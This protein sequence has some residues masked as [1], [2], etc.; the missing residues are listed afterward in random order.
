M[1]V[2]SHMVLESFVTTAGASVGVGEELAPK[3]AMEIVTEGPETV[4]GME[5]GAEEME[6]GAVAVDDAA[7]L[8]EAGVEVERGTAG[9]DEGRLSMVSMKGWTMLVRFGKSG[10]G[11]ILVV[12]STTFFYAAVLLQCF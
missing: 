5:E 4:G 12:K 7:A 8:E 6:A 11:A 2:L 10:A 3:R 9:G 1:Q